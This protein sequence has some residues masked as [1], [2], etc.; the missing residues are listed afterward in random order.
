MTVVL[1]TY[2][3]IS[4]TYL[5]APSLR[6]TKQTVQLIRKLHSN[7]APVTYNRLATLRSLSLGCFVVPIAIGTPRNDGGVREVCSD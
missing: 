5:E 4:K 7:N 3:L 6:G 2:A 1:S